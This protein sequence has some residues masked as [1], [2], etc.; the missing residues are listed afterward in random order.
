MTGIS[1]LILIRCRPRPRM[2]VEGRDTLLNPIPELTRLKRLCE[3][4][5]QNKKGLRLRLGLRLGTADPDRS[6]GLSMRFFRIG[7]LCHVEFTRT[8]HFFHIV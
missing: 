1:I 7:R 8:K 2:A 4:D 3:R 6:P 5:D